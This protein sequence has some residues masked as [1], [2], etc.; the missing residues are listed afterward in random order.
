MKDMVRKTT[1]YSLLF[2]LMASPILLGYQVNNS[3]FIIS[4]SL[5]LIAFLPFILGQLNRWGLLI[6]IPLIGL[7]VIHES[8]ITSLGYYLLGVF[9]LLNNNKLGKVELENAIDIL[10]G[11]L[12]ITILLDYINPKII[13]SI[14]LFE[15]RIFIDNRIGFIEIVRPVGFFRE[16]SGLGLFLGS[17]YF[18]VEFYQL[19][20]RKKLL[21]FIGILSLSASFLLTVFLVFILFNPKK[22]L[23][24]YALIFISIL[25]VIIIT[26]RI[27]PLIELIY[28]PTFTLDEIKYIPLSVIKRYWHPPMALIDFIGNF[29]VSEIAF[30]IGPGNYKN[31][32]Q[33]E[34]S[35]IAGSDL[36][37][38]FILNSII[39]FIFSYGILLTGVI[40]IILYKKKEDKRYF[41]FIIFLLIQGVPLLHPSIF[42]QTIS[43][44]EC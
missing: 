1:I 23:N 29:Q 30:G 28:S 13:N 8:P 20:V 9:M 34:Y 27:K 32:L 22:L 18:L 15:R 17:L 3:E 5:F 38:G 40:L 43:P 41:W 11:F 37:A 21:F 44:K 10:L 33:S 24:K 39:N 26:P 6:L 4:P 19:K 14:S 7:S 35:D 36:R 16:N 42:L 12:L 25:I 2:T 31:Y